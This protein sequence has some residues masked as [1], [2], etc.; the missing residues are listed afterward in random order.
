[1]VLTRSNIFAAFLLC[2]VGKM[3]KQRQPAVYHEAR[4]T[5][6]FQPFKVA[7]YLRSQP[8]GTDLSTVEGL[9]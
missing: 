3:K 2:E 4:I 6:Y 5:V 7:L 9:T 1:M 8:A